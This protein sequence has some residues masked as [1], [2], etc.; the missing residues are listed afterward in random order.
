MRSLKWASARS[1][2]FSLGSC[3]R[4]RPVGDKPRTAGAAQRLPARQRKVEAATKYRRRKAEYFKP[5]LESGTSFDSPSDWWCRSRDKLAAYFPS[6][7][8]LR[9]KSALVEIGVE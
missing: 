6:S 7:V 2:K 8:T 3:W 9:S 1:A 5:N 4:P